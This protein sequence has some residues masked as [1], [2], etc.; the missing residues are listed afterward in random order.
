ML[1]SHLGGRGKVSALWG[2]CPVPPR[3]VRDARP[4][5]FS[6]DGV[7]FRPT[8]IF[9]FSPL[10]ERAQKNTRSE[11]LCPPAALCLALSLSGALY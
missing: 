7:S 4:A 11:C 10:G 8:G 5:S 2:R 3:L 9:F 1:S 6:E